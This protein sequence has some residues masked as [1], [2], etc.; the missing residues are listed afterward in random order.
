[1]QSEVMIYEKSGRRGRD[2]LWCLWICKD[3]MQ[4]QPPD[5]L[6]RSS[7][8]CTVEETADCKLSSQEGQAI[9]HANLKMGLSMAQLRA[10]PRD[11]TSLEFSVRPGSLLKNSCRMLRMA[12]TRELEPTAST[13]W[14]SDISIPAS[15]TA[16]RAH[17]TVSLCIWTATICL[18]E[19]TLISA[20]T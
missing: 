1:M 7:R 4:A 13:E 11:T 16:C 17:V 2:I 10:Q 19:Y 6:R 5:T 8:S 12:G 9:G 20:T 18:G 3:P 15:A 14:I